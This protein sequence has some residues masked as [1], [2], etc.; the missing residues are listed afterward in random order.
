MLDRVREAISSTLAPWLPDAFVLDL[1]A[2][3]GSLGLEALSRGA[4]VARMIERD[5]EAYA[6]LK[7]NVASL[8]MDERTEAVCGDALDPAAWGGTPADIVFLDPPYPWL[9][10]RKGRASIFAGIQG[11]LDRVLASDGVLV[12]HA[13]RNAVVASE[14]GQG[15]ELAGRTYGSN[16]IW[17]VGHASAEEDDEVKDD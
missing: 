7:R 8:G 4:R 2:G 5:R 1:F 11:L 16:A 15:V 10:E 6:L 14:F 12:F 17:Y 3:S 9:K 13:P